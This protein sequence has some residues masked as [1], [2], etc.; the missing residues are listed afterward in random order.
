MSVF[1]GGG[2]HMQLHL[3]SLSLLK[4][5]VGNTSCFAWCEEYSGN[6]YPSPPLLTHLFVN[7]ILCVLWLHLY[8]KTIVSCFIESDR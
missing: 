1:S 4:T 8:S 2:M 3:I 7:Y 5:V 6:P